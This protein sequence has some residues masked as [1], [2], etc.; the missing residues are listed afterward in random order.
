MS[1]D[2]DGGVRH[3][4]R[5]EWDALLEQCKLARGRSAQVRGH[6]LRTRSEVVESRLLFA[7]GR[8]ERDQAALAERG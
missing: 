6:A 2:N 8:L 1:V 3:V 5:A 7:R 4:T